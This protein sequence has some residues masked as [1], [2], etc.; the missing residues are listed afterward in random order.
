MS[1][2]F[3]IPLRLQE[4]AKKKPDWFENSSPLSIN[5]IIYAIR[6]LINYVIRLLW[7]AVYLRYSVS[8]TSS[9]V[10]SD[11]Q[12][13]T[14]YSFIILLRRFNQEVMPMNAKK[15]MALIATLFPSPASL[16]FAFLLTPQS[17]NI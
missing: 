1:R 17:K 14:V 9:S 7:I 8:V 13:N 11:K 12:D 16:E 15:Q 5:V 4:M 3:V 2:I 6:L 10:C